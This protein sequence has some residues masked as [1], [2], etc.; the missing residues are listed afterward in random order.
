MKN[1]KDELT[2]Q[3]KAFVVKVVKDPV[4][5]AR[6]ILGAELWEREVE[7]LRSIQTGRRTAVKACHGAGKTFSLALAALWWL[8][9]YEQGIVLTTAPTF[10]QVRTQL[11]LEIHRLAERAKIPYPPSELDGLRRKPC[12]SS[13]WVF[14]STRLRNKS[15]ALVAVSR[16]R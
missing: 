6:H 9:R 15:A 3:Q 10:R 11:W 13:A 5:F 1:D 12:T 4:A 14:R 2:R 8:A 7:I 16:R